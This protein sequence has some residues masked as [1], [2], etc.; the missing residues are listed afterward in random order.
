MWRPSG[1]TTSSTSWREASS[2]LSDEPT[3][4]P[5]QLG[6]LILGQER[7]AVGDLDQPPVGKELGQSAP[8]LW[9][10]DAILLCPDHECRTLERPQA[11]GRGEHVSLLR[12]TQVP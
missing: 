2:G 11:L 7:V 6:G 4:L 1:S 10:H 12:R 3:N 5:S 8:M 9:G